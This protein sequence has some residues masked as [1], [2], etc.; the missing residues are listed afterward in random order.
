VYLRIREEF[1]KD[2]SN[3]YIIRVIN[4]MDQ[5]IVSLVP[6]AALVRYSSKMRAELRNKNTRNSKIPVILCVLQIDII[7]ITYLIEYNL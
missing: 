2:Y 5:A 4:R 7:S 6:L 3:I 1:A